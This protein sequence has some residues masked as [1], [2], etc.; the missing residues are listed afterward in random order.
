LRLDST[1]LEKRGFLKMSMQIFKKM[2]TF[3]LNAE[4]AWYFSEKPCQGTKPA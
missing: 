4:S 2:R 1:A 3:E